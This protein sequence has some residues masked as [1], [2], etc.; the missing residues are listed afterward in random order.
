[1]KLFV[2]L[3]LM[4]AVFSINPVNSTAQSSRCPQYKNTAISAGWKESEW[5]RLDYIIWRE[6][7]CQPGV[8]NSRGRDDSYGLIQLNMRAHR[9]WVGP[10]VGWNFNALYDPYTNLKIGRDLYRRAQR[11]FDCGWHPWQTRNSRWCR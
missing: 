4:I 1:M 2:C 9:S 3:C 11:M 7:R 10:L 8:R 6:S 5:P